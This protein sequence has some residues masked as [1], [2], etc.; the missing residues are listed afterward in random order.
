MKKAKVIS[1]PEPQA[2]IE[3]KQKIGLEYSGELITMRALRK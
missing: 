2:G 3:V 1:T